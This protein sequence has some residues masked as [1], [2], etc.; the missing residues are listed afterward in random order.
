[1]GFLEK[2]YITSGATVEQIMLAL[3]KERDTALIFDGEIAAPIKNE[4]ILFFKSW[5]SYVYT[6]ITPIP[7]ET[8]EIET[9][10][11]MLT[12]SNVR[13]QGVCGEKKQ[14]IAVILIGGVEQ[15][16]EI[17]EDAVMLEPIPQITDIGIGGTLGTTIDTRSPSFA[18]RQKLTMNAT[19]YTAGF[20]STGKKPGDR[21]YGIT[22][23]GHMV[24]RG[25]VAVDPK[26]IPLGT[27]LYVEGYGYSLAADTGKAIIGNKIDLY[28]E[29][30]AEARQFGRRNL[31]V[32]ILDDPE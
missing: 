18:Y 27:M 23:S 25:V 5:K 21:D 3:Q 4:D 26:I 31:T 22:K 28:V 13:Q 15:N 32:Y 6:E 20:E 2:R 14:T 11:L 16:S 8:L 29:T 17:I 7:F 1:M 30:E 12:K 19:A 9:T 10:A 24:E